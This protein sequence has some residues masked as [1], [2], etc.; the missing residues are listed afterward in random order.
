[1]SAHDDLWADGAQAVV[2]AVHGDPATYTPAGGTPTAVTLVGL[3]HEG[4]E[5]HAEDN[6]RFVK[7]MAV[8]SVAIGT[9]PDPKH[10]D[11]VRGW[12]LDWKVDG[13]PRRAGSFWVL[14]LVRHERVELSGREARNRR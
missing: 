8:A 11:S 2:E 1:M 4:A 6:G 10:G 12:D 5:P 13:S 14:G 7:H 3:R 9:L